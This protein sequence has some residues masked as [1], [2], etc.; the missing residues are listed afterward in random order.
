[1]PT[2]SG[3]QPLNKNI[4]VVGGGVTGMT[5]ALETAAA[6]YPV[7]LVCDEGELG[8]VWKDLYKRVP[9]RAAAADVPNG[10]DVD[11]PGPEEPG[12]A[13]MIERVKADSRITVHL[14]A[15]L[16]KT[17]GAPGRFS[18]DISTESGATVTENFGAIIQASDY[19]PYDASKLPEFAYG[20]TP[21]VV[22]NFE[23]ERLAKA[24]NGGPI[25]R[26]SDG[27]VVESVA[28]IQCAGQRSDKEGHLPYCSGFC[29]TE[30]IK[31]AIYFKDQN[32]DCDTT[33]LFD[34]LR[35]PGAAGEDFYRCGQQ[36]M[37]TFSKGQAS[38]VVQAGKGLKV[39]FQDL[40]L[41]E[42]TEMDC[43]LVVLA[44][45]QVPNN[46]PDPYAQLAVDEAESEE[47]KEAARQ[48]LAVAPPS[49]L[50]LDY[51]QGTDLPQ[52]KH[53]FLDSHFICF[54]YETRRTGIYAA[55]PVRRPMDMKQAMD[56]AVGAAM[57]AIQSA[58][59]AAHSAAVASARRGPELPELPQGRL[60]PVQALHG[61]MP[62]RRHQRGRAALP[63]LQRIALPPLRHLHGRLPGARH[64]L[65]ELLHRQRQPADQGGR[66]PRRVLREAAHP[67]ASPARTTPIR[68]STWPP[69]RV[70]IPRPSRASC[71]CAVWAR[72]ASPGSPTRSTPASTASCSWAAGATRTISATSCAARRSPPSV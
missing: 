28:F 8:G 58:E 55:G 56:D 29:C 30:S 39:Q 43:D 35:T 13:E 37:V 23:L 72:S 48:K 32:P 66:H 4:L 17:S 45:G 40:I 69:R 20:K 16:S 34:D 12:I 65:R 15:K 44:T 46:G 10:R 67:R 38:A 53:G 36:K 63:G 6:G 49:I 26:P 51:R 2:P 1:M 31:Q 41:N 14:N 9:F 59:S 21:D 57:K 70:S 71:R 60:H 68:R 42:A 50:N 27:K 19:K 52:L 62:L 24:A 11:L 22:T 61:G 64:L 3:E 5:A 47:E 18:A 7:H 25:K 33:I 54:P